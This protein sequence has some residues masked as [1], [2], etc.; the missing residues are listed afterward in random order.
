[1]TAIAGALVVGLLFGVALQ[2]GRFCGA[3]LLSAVVLERDLRGLLGIVAAVL[4]SLAGFA[5]LAQF[6]LIIPS[7][8]PMRLASALVGGTAFGVGMVLAGGCVTGTL[9]KAAEGRVLSVLA[10]LGIGLGT[11]VVDRGPGL[12]LKKALVDATRDIRP[13][14]ALDEVVGLSY[15]TLGLLFAPAAL[16]SLVAWLL[17]LRERGDGP[18]R[19]RPPWHRARWSP[20]TA[21]VAIGALGWAAYLV[22]GAAGRNY[23]LGGLGGVRG[24]FN[25]LN[26]GE[27]GSSTF[28]VWLVIGLV[29][30]AALSALVQG[31][32][33]LRSADPATLLVA[34]VGGLLVGAGA[35]IGRGCFIGHGV[36]GVALL[37]LHSMLFAACVA[38][39][40]WVTTLLYL[41]G[42][43]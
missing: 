13:P 26:T 27:F 3:S 2:R 19:E 32:W 37:S 43:R 28:M 5:V 6:D 29:L 39:A 7:P 22:S 35:A 15:P 25:W 1:M 41:R 33:S 31:S 36:S 10:L 24:V 42:V 40:N 4:V 38:A 20:V 16:I 9:Y 18:P 14:P 8:K 11:A 30:G 21:G 23:G 12:A 17:V 34:L